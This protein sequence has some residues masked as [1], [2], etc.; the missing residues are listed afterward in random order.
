[1]WKHM[2]DGQRTF[3]CR[4]LKDSS[5]FR[6]NFMPQVTGSP[7][8]NLNVVVRKSHLAKPHVTKGTGR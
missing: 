5:F 8:S 7:N 6:R 4:E 1:M 3:H 2:N